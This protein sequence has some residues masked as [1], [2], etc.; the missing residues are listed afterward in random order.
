M[1]K[2]L[3]RILAG[4]SGVLFRDVARC[5]SVGGGMGAKEKKEGRKGSFVYMELV[6]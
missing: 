5:G 3:G 4:F 6:C 1:L 2:F